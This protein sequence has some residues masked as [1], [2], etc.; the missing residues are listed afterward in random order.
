MEDE[1]VMK[2]TP[3]AQIVGSNK[4]L[5]TFFRCSPIDLDEEMEDVE[6]I[7]ETST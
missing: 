4:V 7:N 1:G 5:R 6:E 2:P 3:K